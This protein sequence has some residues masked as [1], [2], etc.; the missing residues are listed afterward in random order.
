MRANDVVG[1][2]PA[3]PT[4]RLE[5]TRAGDRWG[6][7]FIDGSADLALA[8][9]LTFATAEEA[10]A[11]ARRAYPDVDSVTVID[12]AGPSTRNDEARRRRMIQLG[13]GLGVLAALALLFFA[14][15][16][17]AEH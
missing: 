7:R 17:L 8:G 14:L 5:I 1:D 12:G 2:E 11:S 10:E 9:N 13:K 6:W 3:A 15:R 4:V 16:R